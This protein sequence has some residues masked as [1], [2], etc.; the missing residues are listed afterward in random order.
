MILTMKNGIISMRVFEVLD[1][2]ARMNNITDGRWAKASGLQYAPRVAE[3]RQKAKL[4]RLSGTDEAK[5]VG[6]AFNAKKC[7]NLVKGLTV[8]LG[9]ETVNK[10]LLDLIKN[11]DSQD[12][13]LLLMV[14]AM[15][16]TNKDQLEAYMEMALKA[17]I[18]DKD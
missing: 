13:R 6:R 11:A 5:K 15:P 18:L 8:I 10:N 12:E 17:D 14:L 1:Q 7:E 3:L 2:I 9:R 4:E 16:N